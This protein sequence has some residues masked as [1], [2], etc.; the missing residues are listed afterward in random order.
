MS[1]LF[2][3]LSTV[4]FILFIVG[5]FN[6]K[7]SLFWMN[8]K[9]KRTRGVSA[10]IYIAIWL[11]LGFIG[12]ALSTDDP[13]TSEAVETSV[14]QPA[15]QV[16]TVK[17]PDN[18]EYYEKKDEMSDEVLY[19]A[20]CVS[21]NMHE[22]DFPYNGGSYLYLKIRNMNGKNDVFLQISKGQIMTSISG[23][24]YVRFKFDGGEPIKYSFSSSSDGDPTY[25]FINQSNALIKKIKAAKDIKID[26][27][28]FQEGRP[29][30]N[31]DVSGLKWD[32]K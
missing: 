12:G 24:E 29:V 3:L 20:S 26:I 5:L 16:E 9:E 10:G 18:W 28:M 15:N 19:I 27:P 22:F 21:T 25:A 11:V 31:F 13:S 14:A 23:S 4:G 2:M 7:A 6:P 17:E 30:F 8:D 32:H 1:T